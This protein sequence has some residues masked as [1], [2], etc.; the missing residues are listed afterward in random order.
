MVPNNDKIKFV[1]TIDKIFFVSYNDKIKF[2]KGTK[3]A[4]NDRTSCQKRKL[5]G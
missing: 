3:Y 4:N 2:V 1:K 5:L